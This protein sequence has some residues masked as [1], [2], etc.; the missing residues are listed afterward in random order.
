MAKNYT[1]YIIEYDID[2]KV[3][4]RFGIPWVVCWYYIGRDWLRYDIETSDSH[5]YEYPKYVSKAPN[6]WFNI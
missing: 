6:I 1:D 3:M 4:D 5:T 2:D